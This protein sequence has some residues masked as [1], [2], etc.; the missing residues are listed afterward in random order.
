MQ[1]I[2]KLIVL[3]LNPKDGR[4]NILVGRTSKPD[5]LKLPEICLSTIQHTQTAKSV[6]HNLIGQILPVNR[7]W[8]E[9]HHFSTTL[10]TGVNHDNIPTVEVVFSCCVPYDMINNNV[11][12]LDNAQ[13]VTSGIIETDTIHKI[14]INH[15]DWLMLD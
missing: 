4:L 5:E 6:C 10:D 1:V 15:N 12:W 9:L 8:V 14:C 13:A 3:S 2:V 7:A 11:Q